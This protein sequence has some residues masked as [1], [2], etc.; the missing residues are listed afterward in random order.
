MSVFEKTKGDK[1]LSHQAVEKIVQ[2]HHDITEAGG[3]ARVEMF[4]K[5]ITEHPELLR[6]ILLEPADTDAAT[7]DNTEDADVKKR[8]KISNGPE[9]HDFH[10][11]LDHGKDSRIGKMIK[12]DDVE[13]CKARCSN[14][15]GCTS[16]HYC[17]S[18]NR[19]TAGECF[20]SSD[21]DGTGTT[22][23]S[24]CTHVHN[25]RKKQEWVVPVAANEPPAEDHREGSE[26]DQ[27]RVRDETADQL[28][29][30]DEAAK[31]LLR[32]SDEARV[33]A[34]TDEDL[35][36]QH[37]EYYDTSTAGTRTNYGAGR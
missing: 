37:T 31:E 29:G 17:A 8:W 28:L 30:D 11:N 24:G 33:K 5:Y 18:G 13:L 36:Q 21:W 7:G 25:F 4:E 6:E 14:T 20:I 12:T 10:D 1:G 27:N 15:K 35:N 3:V 9:Y 19:Q 34:M 22:S 32:S 23:K 26:E 2:V 16:G